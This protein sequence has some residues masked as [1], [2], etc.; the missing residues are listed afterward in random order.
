ML[1]TEAQIIGYYGVQSEALPKR[2]AGANRM[3][4]HAGASMPYR[5]GHSRWSAPT[6]PTYLKVCRGEPTCSPGLT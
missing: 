4:S 5:I 2:D 6:N 3:G 1:S